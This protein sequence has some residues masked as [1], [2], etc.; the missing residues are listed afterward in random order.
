MIQIF[1]FVGVLIGLIMSIQAKAIPSKSEKEKSM[2]VTPETEKMDLVVLQPINEAK[3]KQNDGEIMQ[4]ANAIV[5]RPL[6]AYRRMQSQRSRVYVQ[7][8]RRPT[9]YYY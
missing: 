6:F 4:T 3:D 7:P 5:F 1:I 9:Y 2:S 8:R